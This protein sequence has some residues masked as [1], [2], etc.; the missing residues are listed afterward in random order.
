MESRP[1]LPHRTWKQYEDYAQG[2][3]AAAASSDAGAIP[4]FAARW[5]DD[6]A[7]EEAE[8]QGRLRGRPVT[9]QLREM[10][11]REELDR[12][13]K[14]IRESDLGKTSPSLANAQRLVARAFGFDEWSVFAGHAEA[15]QNTQSS[16]AR[17]EAAADAIVTGDIVTV[18]RLLSEDPQLIQARSQRA[19]HAPLLHYV[20]ANGIEGFRQRS[21]QNIV[22]I[23]KLLLEAGADV[24]AESNAYGGGSTALGLVAASVHPER[25]GVQEPLMQILLDHGAVLDV[26]GVAGNRHTAIEGCLRNG[27]PI[28]ARFLGAR[29]A[30]LNLETAAGIGRLDLIRNYFTED[31]KLAPQATREQLQRGFLWAC[32]F[33]FADVVDFLLD[34]G[35]DLRDRADI[36]ATGLHWAVGGGH[37]EIVRFLLSRG[38]PLEEK[39]VWDGTALEHCGW[40]FVNADLHIDFLPMFALLLSSGAHIGNGWLAWLAQQPWRTETE[41]ERVA[42]LF[43]RHGAST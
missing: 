17:F 10:A 14:K 24:N 19:H 16:E 4:A 32:M 13:E 12:I 42:E 21:P 3:L 37:L 35:A 22:E 27:R 33:G 26:P 34:R 29:G 28:A 23:A 39:N 18:K 8:A 5:V 25:A 6:Y 9:P 38:A 43:R 11:R 1:L 2:L 7:E 31:G 15:L 20:A 36:G 41:R 30:A 40:A